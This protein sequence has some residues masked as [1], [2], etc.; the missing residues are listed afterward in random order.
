M[1]GLPEG[2]PSARLPEVQTL[3]RSVLTKSPQEAYEAAM[4]LSE[5]AR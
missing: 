5:A 4:K 2:A 3:T 1:S